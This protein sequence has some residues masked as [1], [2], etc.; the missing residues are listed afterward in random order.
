[1]AAKR[2][3][4]GTGYKISLFFFIAFCG[5]LILVFAL[6]FISG[7]SKLPVLG[8]PGHITGSF[9]LKDQDGATITEAGVRDKI[10]VVE[11][12]FTTCKGICPIMNHNLQQVDQAFEDRPDVVILSHTVD[13]EHDSVSVM[14]EYAHSMKAK[15]DKWYFLTG[16]KQELYSLA[17]RDYLLS[18]DSASGEDIDHQ[19]IHTAYVALVDKQ[20]RI[21]GFYDAT[22]EKEIVRLIKDIKQL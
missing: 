11:Y 8:Q 1:M 12:F 20:N 3:R 4:R 21:R 2:S 14:R 13:P 7:K 15:A 5:A 6:P 18:V 19:F 17:I 22:N 10:R 9:S 16:S